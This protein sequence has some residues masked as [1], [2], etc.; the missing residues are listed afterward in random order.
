MTSEATLVDQHMFPRLVVRV[1][2]QVIREI[3]LR[4]DLTIGRAEDNDLQVSDPKVSRHHAQI[5]SA[6][7]VFVIV[8]LG[9]ANGTLVN[10]ERLADPHT[11]RHGERITVGDTELTY[12]EP[13]AP[14][15]ATIAGPVPA[16]AR[17]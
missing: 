2:G 1:G 5:Q 14:L 7:A 10:G 13:G 3:D 9:S 16:F 8:D 12:E 15:D 6:A 11:L 4:G 17:L